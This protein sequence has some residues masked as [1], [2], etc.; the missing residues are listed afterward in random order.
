[1]IE[2]AEFTALL[3][4]HGET[5]WSASGRHT[6]NTDVPLTPAGTAQAE[7]LRPRVA[8]RRLTL[9]LCSP[10]TRARATCTA[11]GLGGNT[12]LRDDLRE[13]DYGDYEGLT[14]A[15][16]RQ[17]DPSWNLWQRGCPGGERPKAV[18]ARCDRVIAELR[19]HAERE[20]GD[21]I[22]FA[23]GHILR[24]LTAR[25][26]TRPVLFG[27]HLMLSTAATSGLGFEHAAPAIKFWNHAPPSV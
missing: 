1:M 19:A 5:E 22:V 24:A 7:A 8:E 3:V 26:C 15:Q 2:A 10:L 14:L 20:D 12:Q 9:V 17:L 6:G 4:R 16:I 13:W 11:A 21:A 27:E 18:A 23:H 25:W